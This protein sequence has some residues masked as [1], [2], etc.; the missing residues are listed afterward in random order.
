MR[1][2]VLQAIAARQEQIGETVA[3]AAG[4]LLNV[5]PGSSRLEESRPTCFAGEWQRPEKHRGL[6]L[7]TDVACD[8]SRQ[9]FPSSSKNPRYRIPRR[10]PALLLLQR[11]VF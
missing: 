7:G 11:R 1:V 6:Q 9:N 5:R 8:A 2:C 10:R 3:A 4:A